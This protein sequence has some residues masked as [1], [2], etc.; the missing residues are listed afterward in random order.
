MGAPRG[1][2]EEKEPGEEVGRVARGL[3]EKGEWCLWEAHTGDCFREG[4]VVGRA[5]ERP[6]EMRRG[7]DPPVLATL[8]QSGPL[9]SG[10][11]RGQESVVG[12]R[13]GAGGEK[14][15]SVCAAAERLGK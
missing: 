2:V 4:L 1:Q 5:C 7:S 14:G 9:H 13:P 11:V 3:E 12:E 6:S 15:E 10:G 8:R